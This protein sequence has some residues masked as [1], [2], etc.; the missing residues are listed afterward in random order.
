MLKRLRGCVLTGILAS[1]LFQVAAPA[2]AKSKGS[3]KASGHTHKKSHTSSPSAFKQPAYWRRDAK[4][5][6]PK[7]WNPAERY[8]HWK[9]PCSGLG[10][11]P[12]TWPRSSYRNVHRGWY[13]SSTYRNWGWWGSRSAAWEYGALAAGALIGAAVASAQR[14]QAP[15]ISVP[16]SSY[17][18]VYGSVQ[19]ETDNGIRFL[20]SRDGVTYQMD[21][22]CR[23]G[24]LNGY[25]PNDRSEAQLL[26]AACQVAYGS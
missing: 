11:D 8:N 26:N 23:D 14:S 19:A 2:L 4:R 5:W 10:C 9:R 24:E 1:M 18:L 3:G 16:D 21:A 22:D 12:R 13:N 25:A 17:Q 6:K 20:V 7:N 15:T